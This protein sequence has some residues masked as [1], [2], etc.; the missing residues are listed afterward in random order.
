MENYME[1]NEESDKISYELYYELR[2]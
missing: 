2:L 1:H